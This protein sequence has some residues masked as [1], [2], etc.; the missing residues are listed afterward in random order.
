VHEFYQKWENFSSYKNFSW[1][2][3][4]RVDE[5]NRFVKRCIERE[6]NKFRVKERKAYVEMVK[7]IVE[8]AFKKGNK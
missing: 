3:Q 1:A 8:F 2:D 6:N 4:Y 5:E 7:K